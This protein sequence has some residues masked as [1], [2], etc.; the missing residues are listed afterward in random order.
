[1]P[2][3]QLTAYHYIA[4]DVRAPGSQRPL[5]V[6]EF[7]EHAAFPVR[8]LCSLSVHR[9]LSGE[10]RIHTSDGMATSPGENNSPPITVRIL[11][12]DDDEAHAQAVADSLSAD[13]V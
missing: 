5:L 4:V 1:M 2:G 6:G 7:P 12:V 10:F 13:D 3:P 8:T 11:V 9:Y